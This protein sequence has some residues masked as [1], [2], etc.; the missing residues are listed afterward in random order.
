VRACQLRCRRLPA[1]DRVRD[2]LLRAAGRIDVQVFNHAPDP[3]RRERAL[4]AF[5]ARAFP[6]RCEPW[7]ELAADPRTTDEDVAAVDTAYS[8]VICAASTLLDSFVDQHEDAASGDHSYISHYGDPALAAERVAEI[9]ARSC[10]EARALRRG[11]R[12]A[13]IAGGIV[14]MYL[15]KDDARHPALRP[16][17]RRI[18]RG[19]GPL[20]RAQLPIM[21]A[22]RVVRR[23]TAA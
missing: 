3:A 2:R 14:A 17:A 1:Y 16:A 21:R 19:A 7:F 22:M 12:H 8:F 9:V 15:S 10:A 23:L 4:R 13:L 18:L 11:S 6:G 5:A 20:P